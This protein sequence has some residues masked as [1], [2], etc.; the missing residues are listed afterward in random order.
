MKAQC[1]RSGRADGKSVGDSSSARLAYPPGPGQAPPSCRAATL[2]ATIRAIT[3][4]VPP[5]AKG[6]PS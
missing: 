6:T 1:C 3:S 2:S 4:V 5:A